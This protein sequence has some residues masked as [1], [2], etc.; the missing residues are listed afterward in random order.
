L[1]SDRNK[2]RLERIERELQEKKNMILEAGKEFRERDNSM[3]VQRRNV[4]VDFQ[5]MP[6]PRIKQAV[7]KVDAWIGRKR[8]SAALVEAEPRG[9]GNH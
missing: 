3:P 5:H 9:L 2:E 6:K 7:A 4:A 1:Y 8:Q